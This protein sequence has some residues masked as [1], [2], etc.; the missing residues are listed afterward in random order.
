MMNN[1][2]KN[3]VLIIDDERANIITL[4]KI[5]ESEYELYAAGDGQDGIDAAKE[6][7][8]DVILLDILMPGMDGYEAL[9]VLQGMEKTKEIPVIFISGLVDSGSEEK[10]L[11]LGAADYI[12]KPF[13]PAVVRLRVRNQINILK[14][15][16]A[17]KAVE[18]QSKK[19]E[20]LAHWYESI[21]DAIPLPVTVTDADMNWTFVNAAVEE[22]LGTKRAD[23]MGKPCSNWNAHICNTPECGI[24]C[25]KRGLK[26]TFFTQKERSHQVD[27][28]ILKDMNGKTSGYI[29]IVQDITE[30]EI[31]HMKQTNAEAA[32]RAKSDFLAR[33]SHEVRTP[34]NAILGITEI[35]LL[36]ENL[37]PE[38]ED[39]LE[40]I[41]NSG[42][43]LLGIINDIL[44]LSKIEA[45]KLELSPVNY[46]V[47]SLINDIVHLNVMRFDSK[48][49]DFNLELDE[50]IPS[51]LFGD[52]LRIKQIL[53]NLLSNAFKYTD[54]GRIIL[55]IVAE[56][57]EPN[58]TMFPAPNATQFPAQDGT[59]TL[60]FRVSDTGQGMTEEQVSK[61][62]DE[63]TRFNTEANRTTVGT[64]LGMSITKHLVNMMG[65]KINV[66]SEPK[67]GSVF[68]VRLPQGKVDAGVLGRDLAENLR[69]FR[70]G[71]I[72]QMKKAP[73]IV[74][75]YMPYGSVLVVDD[76]ETNLYVAKGLMSPYGLSIE[77]AISGFEAINKINNGGRYDIVFM[78][79]FMPNMDGIEA[80][81][82]IR[83]TGY[84]QPIVALTAN[85][86][87]GQAEMFVANGFDDF[88][89]KP[90]DLRQLNVILNKLI[91]DKQ[92]PE[93]IVAARRLKDGQ[94]K[95]SV[96]SKPRIDPVL[97][98]VFIRDAER[99]VEVL[100]MIFANK[101]RRADDL[102]MFVINTHAMKSAL[103][104]IGEFKLSVDAQKLE[105]VGREVNIELILSE[106][107]AFINALHELIEKF[108]SKEGDGE[109]VDEDAEEIR[110]YLLNK[111]LAVQAAIAAFDKAAVKK[112]M[113]ELNKKNWSAETKELLN[114]ISE[115]LLHSE[116]EEAANVVKEYLS[117]A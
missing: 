108:R 69:Q 54:E 93:V 10:G 60:V 1:I 89:S 107:P 18:E 24:A 45:G 31:M 40:R 72:S 27:V 19:V 91:R 9:S 95:H 110:S 17:A 98:K 75:D 104:N 114:V 74:R 77:T 29:E 62:F 38:T 30:I 101:C 41:Y 23:I 58:A 67:K 117:Q 32:N 87:T 85:A 8:P 51:T 44:D 112:I 68:T 43:L 102:S 115:H 35:Q 83:S 59:M 70:L 7:L 113:T 20:M 37:H 88:I 22:F 4:T 64:G 105:A 26:R 109:A 39:A 2:K 61:L 28:A 6:H 3:S 80:A 79:H 21:L 33:V 66:E 56:P 116:F 11:D 48:P 92:P 96:G 63:Y 99:A 94:K 78:D 16:R 84:T 34:M 71:K 82:I 13:S 111:L 86:L 46:D 81:K 42:Y 100:E 12:A 52:E 103:A 15:L 90:V 57:A 25:A 14:G 47:P 5:L 50:N 97:A 36:K 76:V 106:L 53:N 65:G 73:Q 49:I 55:S